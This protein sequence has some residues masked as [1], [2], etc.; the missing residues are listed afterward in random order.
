MLAQERHWIIMEKLRREQVVKVGDLAQQ[1]TVSAETIRRDLDVLEQQGCLKKVHGG[2]V[3][4]QVKTYEPKFEERTQLFSENKK[5]LAQLVCK[6]VVE[7]DS[8]ALDAGTTSLE[9][10]R[11][12]KSQYTS[13]TIVTNSIPVV[14]ELMDKPQFSVILAGGAVYGEEKAIVGGACMEQIRQY[15]VNHYFL[16]PSGISLH[17]GVTSYDLREAEI[18]RTFAEVSNHV[19][20]FCQSGAFDSASLV[21]VCDLIRVEEIVTDSEL[22]QETRERYESAGITVLT[23]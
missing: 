23:P 22:P 8:I 20:V 11:V 3:L 14:C 13:L 21:K 10:A 5:E 7:G 6:L 4:E 19:V 1:L 2:A 17:S 15:R 16:T 18:Q 12:L 9:I